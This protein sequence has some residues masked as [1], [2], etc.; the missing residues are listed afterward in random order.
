MTWIVSDVDGIVSDLKS[1]GV[2]FERYDFPE[3]KHE[4]DVHV[5]GKRRTAWFKDPDGKIL[6]LGNK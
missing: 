6:A 4:G 3:V 5:F 2:V 1:K